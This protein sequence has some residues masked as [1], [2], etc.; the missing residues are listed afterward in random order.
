MLLSCQISH[1]NYNYTVCSAGSP[2]GS[3]SPWSSD[4]FSQGFPCWTC[5]CI[6]RRAPSLHFLGTR[7]VELEEGTGPRCSI[8]S[9][10]S[11]V[12]GLW[13]G[14]S[15]RVGASA[16]QVARYLPPALATWR[17]REALGWLGA[18]PVLRAPPQPPV[19]GRTS[20]DPA[21]VASGAELAQPR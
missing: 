6:A 17:G 14:G 3:D 4:L 15:P 21:G 11:P 9:L 18:G 5:L 1:H 10:R 13:G 12:N 8:S 7:T 19:P 16:N 20:A 2:V